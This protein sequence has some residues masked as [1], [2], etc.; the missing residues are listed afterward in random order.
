M[1]SRRTHG[2][3]LGLV[4]VSVLVVIIIGVGFYFLSKMFGGGREVANATDAGILNAAKMALRKGQTNLAASPDEQA[5]AGCSDTSMGDAPGQISM[6][7]LNRVIAQAVMI[8]LNAGEEGTTAASTNA[9][10]AINTAKAISARIRAALVS[11]AL[12]GDFDSIAGAA[13]N[14]MWGGAANRSGSLTQSYMKRRGSTNVY[15]DPALLGGT[16]D[17]KWALISPKLNPTSFKVSLGGSATADP[18]SPKVAG[19]QFMQGYEPITVTGG[20]IYGTPV[21]PQTTPHLVAGNDFSAPA[22]AYIAG[23]DT[24]PNAFMAVTSA[25]EQ[26]SGNIGGSM[27]AA[28][29]GCINNEYLA[30][31]PRGYVRVWNGPDANTV[32]PPVTSP[33]FDATN[34]IFANELYSPGITVANND[35]FSLNQ[36]GV[37]AW[38]DYNATRGWTDPDTASPNYGQPSTLPGKGDPALWPPDIS[39]LHDTVDPFGNYV[40][41]DASGNGVSSYMPLLTDDLPGNGCIG[42]V[43]HTC[44]D[45]DYDV[46]MV[47]QKCDDLLTAFNTAYPPPPNTTG[48]DDGGKGF[49]ALE[50]VKGKVLEGF[51][52]KC[53][54]VPDPQPSGLKVW[55]HNIAHPMLSRTT[56]NFGV[57][58]SPWDL[59]EQTN[60]CGS[61]TMLNLI[62]GRMRQVDSS[63]STGDVQSALDSM[64]LQMYPKADSVLY[65]YS[66]GTAPKVKC[67]ATVPWTGVLP[68]SPDMLKPD[69]LPNAALDQSATNNVSSCNKTYN[70][71]YRGVDDKAGYYGAGSK[72]DANLHDV[73]YK[74]PPGSV[75]AVDHCTWT[76]SSGYRNML[77]EVRFFNDVNG[78]GRFCKPN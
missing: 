35:V 13:K 39:N 61:G 66:D 70:A 52:A 45:V 23:S 28:I 8:G 27:A 46:P 33:V 31:I 14:Q 54:T 63:I 49:T 73:P 36:P 2:A 29:L 69:G 41:Y 24:P 34:D 55:N 38:A 11:S 60:S 65:L 30:R 53:T 51:N 10:S 12:D 17:P 32:N 56:C 42:S 50:W 67:A 22:S 76:P 48:V 21:F 78:S 71:K 20:T 40:Y 77:G 57:P 62:T 74:S 19:M 1:K 58:G 64:A 75:D 44:H 7:T 26:K 59:M 68:A 3:T 47:V 9:T 16:G 25:N 15:F 4:A 43:Y 6:L 37:Q 72:G 18:S 5:F